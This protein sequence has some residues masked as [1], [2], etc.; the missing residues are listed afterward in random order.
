[1]SRSRK[2]PRPWTDAED[3]TL[4]RMAAQGATARQ[5]ADELGRDLSMICNHARRKRLALK[6]ERKPRTRWTQEMDDY[7][8]AHYADTPTRHIADQMGLSLQVIQ[9]RVIVL[10]LRKSDAF[11]AAPS[12]AA[13]KHVAPFKPGKRTRL[14]R[15]NHVPVGAEKFCPNRQALIRK[16]TDDPAVFPSLRWQPVH[17]LV[18]EAA[19][20]PVPKGHICVFKPGL[21]THRPEEITLD[22]LE[23]ISRAE[24]MR[25]NSYR[26]MFPP[27]IGEIIR[28]KGLI[29]RRVNNLEKKLNDHDR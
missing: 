2:R 23:V 14:A 12:R 16:I 9:S 3:A 13:K 19:H 11:L 8:C 24:N 4:V 21:K 29:T 1:M 26:T 22:R 5:I 15:K 6:H 18:W 25:R 17:V 7:L 27:E 28:M 10:G 20:G